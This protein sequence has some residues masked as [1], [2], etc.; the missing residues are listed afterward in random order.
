MLHYVKVVRKQLIAVTY[1]RLMNSRAN[2]SNNTT[3]VKSLTS[4]HMVFADN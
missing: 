3:Q 4:L 2:M 1:S